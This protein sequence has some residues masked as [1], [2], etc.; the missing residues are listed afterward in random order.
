MKFAVTSA[1]FD[2][3]FAQSA[4]TQLE[5][6]DACANDLQVDGVVFDLA[7]L[8]RR[9]AEYLAQLK[10]TATDL[11]VTVAAVEHRGTLDAAAVGEA[12][13][14]AIAIGAPLVVVRAPL[15]SADAE[16]W[17]DFAKDAAAAAS[18]AKGANVTLALRNARETLCATAADLRR[19]AKDVDSAWLRFAVDLAAFGAADDAQALVGRTALAVHH[20]TPVQALPPGLARF[21]G[22]V[23]IERDERTDARGFLATLRRARGALLAHDLETLV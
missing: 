6:L 1:C 22:F 2:V 21:R 18:A 13:A 8:P 5:W 23:V 16:A 7:H 20:G 19:I 9:D 15:A 11:A 17:P 4:T 12:L 10:K 14:I 3:Q